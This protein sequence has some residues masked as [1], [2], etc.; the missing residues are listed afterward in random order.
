MSNTLIFKFRYF[1]LGF[2]RKVS[3]VYTYQKKLTILHLTIKFYE[4]GSTEVKKSLGQPILLTV[5]F[6]MMG[7]HLICSLRKSLRKLSLQVMLSI[8]T[9]FRPTKELK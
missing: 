5:K 7:D 8:S 6:S 4:S 3:P 9:F 2:N 1:C